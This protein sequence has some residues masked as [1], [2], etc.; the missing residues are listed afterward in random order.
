MTYPFQKIKDHYE[1]L[2]PE[3]IRSG[4]KC[5]YKWTSPYCDEIHWPPMFSPIELSTWQSIRAFGKCPLYP[6][7]PVRRYFVDFGNPVVKVALECDGVKWHDKQK[8]E[9]RDKILLD[10]GWIVYRIGG[11]D[12]NRVFSQMEELKEEN[13]YSDDEKYEI[14]SQFYE[15]TVDGLIRAIAVIHMGLR[16][17][18]YHEREML[19]MFRCLK[20]RISIDDGMLDEVFERISMGIERPVIPDGIVR[21]K[22]V[23]FAVDNIYKYGRNRYVP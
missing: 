15:T 11:A 18:F 21:A 5:K 8:D 17:F 23:K 9:E 22:D 1:D 2:L 4:A 16:E 20:R 7:Y 14:L 10:A 3:I 19:L 6:Q 13:Y 12:C